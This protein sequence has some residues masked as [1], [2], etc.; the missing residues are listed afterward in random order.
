MY[1]QYFVL[2]GSGVG[3]L[4]N[5]LLLLSFLLT[6]KEDGDNS[7]YKMGSHNESFFLLGCIITAEQRGCHEP[8]LPGW[9]RTWA[10][11]PSLSQVSH[12]SGRLRSDLVTRS[13]V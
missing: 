4:A 1:S 2:I 5:S 12:Q 7:L 13:E 11:T 6:N 3:K 10:V 9:N 8:K